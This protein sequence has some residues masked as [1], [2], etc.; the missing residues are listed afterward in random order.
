MNTPSHRN[1][2]LKLVFLMIPSNLLSILL[3]EFKTL[4]EKKNHFLKHFFKD[5]TRQT[6]FSGTISQY[7]QHCL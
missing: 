7:K 2:T 4:K 5:L 1:E 6:G 3:G